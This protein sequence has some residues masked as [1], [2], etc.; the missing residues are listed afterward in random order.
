MGLK[1]SISYQWRLFFPLVGLLWFIIIAMAVFQYDRERTYR[2]NRIGDDLRLVNSRIISAYEDS[3]DLAPFIR[4]I[5]NYYENSELNG[6]RVSVYN[7]KGRLL[8]CIGAAIPRYEDGNLPPELANAIVQGFGTSLRRS[9]IKSDKADAPFYYYGA[10]TSADGKIYVHTA[11]PFTDTLYRTVHG[12]NEIIW[13]VILTMAIAA[14]LIAYVSTR[15]LGRN[16]KALHRFAKNVAEGHPTDKNYTFANDELGDISRQIVRIF[17]EKN[18]AT[19][20]SEREHRIAIKA[21]EDKMR[22]T[23]EM[24]NNINHELKTPVGVIKGYIDTIVQ[25]PEMPEQQRILFLQK[26][27]QHMDRL[28]AMLND[29]NT[30]AR[31]ENGSR[32]IIRE[33]VSICD[34]ML[35]IISE[36]ESAHF[37]LNNISFDFD[38][39]EDCYVTGNYNLLYGMMLNLIRNADLHSHGTECRLTCIGENDTEYTF[40]F[41]D[42]GTGVDPEHLPHLFERFYRIDKGRSRK[43]GGSGLGLPI[44]KNTI[45]VH[46]GTIEARNATPHGLQFIFTLPKAD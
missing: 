4:F 44:V 25:H 23:R 2:M 28:C 34:L 6:I 15:Y 32:D 9:D 21:T 14:T 12:N 37:T 17:E 40:S 8:H 30:I 27:Q 41:A 33:K 13:T 7:D 20:R 42:N 45:T 24:S 39:A 38:V 43:A 29:L 16:I 1:R 18:A 10:R 46:G 3:A 22:M 11:M 5:S 31:L 36:L 35:Q 19:I 26:S